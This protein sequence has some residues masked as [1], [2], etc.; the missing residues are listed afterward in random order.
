MA[1]PTG[2]YA[3][4]FKEDITLAKAKGYTGIQ[5]DVSWGNNPSTRMIWR[6]AVQ[7]F[8]DQTE[9]RNTRDM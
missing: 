6:P 1:D 7:E 5:I 9:I 4:F 2:L 8:L 3:N